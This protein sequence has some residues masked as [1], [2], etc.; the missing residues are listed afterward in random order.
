MITSFVAASRFTCFPAPCLSGAAVVVSLF[1]TCFSVTAG[2]NVRFSR[3]FFP[4]ANAQADPYLMEPT[5]QPGHRVVDIIVNGKR[6][7]QREIEFSVRPPSRDV[8][9]CIDAALLRDLPL[10][11]ALLDGTEKNEGCVDLP[12]RVAGATVT[13]VDSDLQLLITIPQA[14][15]PALKAD[16]VSPEER[17]N[18]IS[19]AF[20]DYRARHRITH[21][22]QASSLSLWSG[23]NL[24]SWRLRSQTWLSR[25]ES[26][27]R[28]DSF[29]TALERDLPAS[30]MRMLLGQGSTSGRFFD[31]VPFTGMRIHS[32]ERMLPESMQGYAPTVRGIAQTAAIVRIRQGGRIIRELAVPP[33]P[34]VVDDLPGGSFS[35]DLDVT[36]TG[37]DGSETRYRVPAGAAP[38]A[39][40]HGAEQRSFTVGRLAMAGRWS[41]DPRGFIEAT[42]ARGVAN[43]LTLLGGGHYRRNYQAVLAGG[44]L[45]TPVGALGWDVVSQRLL[46]SGTAMT[47][48]RMGLT[49]AYTMLRSGSSLSMSA[50]SY[51]RAGRLE[52]IDC[53]RLTEACRVSGDA[54]ARTRRRVHSTF[55][56]RVGEVAAIHLS[57][58][59]ESFWNE[60]PN[61]VDL[62][63]GLHGRLGTATWSAT[64]LRR[65]DGGAKAGTDYALQVSV[66]L[67]RSLRSAQATVEIAPGTSSPLNMGVSGVVSSAQAMSYHVS[68]HPGD[69]HPLHQANVAY[70]GSRAG[71][72]AS[73]FLGPWGD[74]Y[75]LMIEGSAI[76]HCDG[77]TFGRSMGG[78]G[79]AAVLVAAPGAQGVGVR[80]V[81][82]LRL[83]RSGYAVVPY[84]TPYRWNR[85]ELDPAGLPLDVELLQTSQR[86]A[87][88]SGSI[89]RVHFDVVQERVLF[90]D[91]IDPAG[92][93]LPFAAPVY[94]PAGRLRGSVAQG[95]VIRLDSSDGEGSVF[96]RPPNAA[97][98]RL[99]YTRPLTADAYGLFWS[100]SVCVPVSPSSAVAP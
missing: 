68:L 81:Q 57:A 99:D 22:V 69:A 60:R 27:T 49:Y 17:D 20:V 43:H 24:G 33:G 67:R 42:Y 7:K 29:N 84:L 38:L 58:G 16:V 9:P 64:V 77:L 25:N 30:G 2:E 83:G 40:R 32:D 96:V 23:I 65:R 56:Q 66:P 100:R 1:G 82:G 70:Q 4:G 18:G 45:S 55:S 31:S 21:N 86:V 44:A 6:L 80:N 90:I 93:R 47:G 50:Y 34:F 79:G 91:A 88:T 94:D 92:N 54:S 76:A 41:D 46:R 28:A 11:P 8:E 95:G 59:W 87:P 53:D 52:N 5:L 14:A 39:L 78:M 19:A 63:L 37:D 51:G 71:I 26:H 97:P 13:H 48:Q 75:D 12:Q 3:N 62:Q 89:V 72:A 61:S 73:A 15:Q 98:C 74:S 36:V 35:G 10:D 85:I